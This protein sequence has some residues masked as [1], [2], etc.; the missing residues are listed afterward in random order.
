MSKE[1]LLATEFDSACDAMYA[2]ADFLR[3]VD[4]S[5]KDGE[6]RGKYQNLRVIG[7]RIFE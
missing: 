7:N 2:L 6:T 4:S 1:E 5:S 3:D